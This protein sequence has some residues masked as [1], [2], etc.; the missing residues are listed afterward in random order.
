MES[1]SQYLEEVVV[2]GIFDRKK[3]GFTGSAV[4]LKGDDLKKY[5]ATNIAKALSAVAP[6]FRIV[7]NIDLGSNPNG[8]PEMSLRGQA[9]MDLGNATMFRCTSQR[10]IT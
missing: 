5:S 7:E 9:N 8:L 6:G 1:D 4:T 3:E 2:T 10:R